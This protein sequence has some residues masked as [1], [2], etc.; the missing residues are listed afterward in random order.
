M[1]K[2]RLGVIGVGYVGELHV[3]KYAA[4]E[5]VDLVG[6]ADRDFARAQEV[7]R[8]YNTTAYSSHE[9]L[10]PFLD[11]ASLAVPTL[12]HF[13]VGYELLRHG[14]NLLIEKPITLNL[15]D[16]ERLIETAKEHDAVLQIG[17]IERFNPAVIKMESLIS[18]PIFIESHRLNFFTNRGTDVDVVLDLMIHDLDIILNI[19][20]ADIEDIDAVG[21]PVV[22]DKIDI[23]NV[24]IMFA[25]GTVANVTASR[26]SSE[27]LRMLR[28]IQPDI[29]I[30]VDYGNKRITVTQLKGDRKHIGARSPVVHREDIFPDSDPLADQLSSFVKAIKK[31]AEPKVSGIDGKNA[32]AVSLAIMEQITRK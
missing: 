23:A 26:V 32:L 12:S 17:H 19:V 13:E 3:Q 25:N 27:S 10:L 31:R 22:S 18:R 1:K 20:N 29:H 30:T 11:G 4:M 14:V 5:D 16:A 6:V 24:R 21:M 7:A 2:L 15:G 8:R 28:I 9:E